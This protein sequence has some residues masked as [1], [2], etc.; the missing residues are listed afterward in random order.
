MENL[1][2]KSGLITRKLA[3]ELL[4]L[5]V[6]DR[7]PKIVDFTEKFQVGRGTI[8]SAFKRLEEL[9]CIK[10]ESKGHLGTFL[11]S[12]NT[13]ELLR[14]A[15]IER[16]T[17][18]MPLPYS[19]KY[20]GIASGLTFEFERLN[21]SLNIA[22]MRGA[23]PRIEGVKEGRYEFALVSRFSALEELEQNKNLEI[24]LSFGEQTYVSTH[25]II[26]AD[27]KK[28]A[29]VDGMKIGVDN[30]STDHKT[31]VYAET[32]DKK[33]D[34][35]ELNYMH[36]LK[37]LQAENI[38]ATIWNLDEI[39]L[40]DFHLRPLSS[41]KALDYGRNMNEAVCIIKKGNKKLEY[42]LELLSKEKVVRIQ[43]LVESGEYIPRY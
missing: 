37:N 4:F 22:F 31:L 25:T 43:S 36:L 26:F 39:D 14:C 6:G 10:T 7:I 19:K 13:K 34:Y 11:R 24:G 41:K 1:F 33:V 35:I 29:I 30:N 2:L 21:L 32:E 17:A 28:S 9:E 40:N 20:E 23:K 42:I 15:G 38:D 27:P 12:K 8:Q 16:I 18:V 5:K 3:E